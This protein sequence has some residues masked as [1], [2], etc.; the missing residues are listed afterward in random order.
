MWNEK[1]SERLFNS[2]ISIWL[3][4]ETRVV[5][6]SDM[7]ERVE[8]VNVNSVVVDVVQLIEASCE[9]RNKREKWEYIHWTGGIAITTITISLWNL[10]YD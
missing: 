2:P 5:D 4:E 6:Y 10:I 8:A 7:N 1:R 9:S 3:N